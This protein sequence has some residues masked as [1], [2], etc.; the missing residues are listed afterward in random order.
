MKYI[1]IFHANLNYAYNLK[2]CNNPDEIFQ[3]MPDA[4]EKL[5]SLIEAV[6]KLGHF[7]T[8]DE[9]CTKIPALEDPITFI[10]NMAWHGGQA[11][12]W[13]GTPMAKLLR[14]WQDLVRQKL[15]ASER[16]LPPKVVEKIW[17]HLTNSYN[18]DGQWPPTTKAS[19]HI[20]YPFN[21]NYNF[22]NLLAAELLLGGIDRSK[23]D[24]DPIKTMKEIFT[25][26]QDLV[27]EKVAVLL[28]TGTAK[29]KEDAL[30]AEELIRRSRDTSSVPPGMR[31]LY[32]SEYESRANMLITARQLV[33]GVVVAGDK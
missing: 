22:E 21:Y 13:S 18:S 17:F 33:G 14:P 31:I 10:D 26:Q 20:I 1:A 32:P 29:Q 8:F 11:S 3:K 9:A 16:T 2:Y 6:R 25:M 15:K 28:G 30:L 24:A 5:V 7:V 23:I 12:N 27:L 19:P 4:E